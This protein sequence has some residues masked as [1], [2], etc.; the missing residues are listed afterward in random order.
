MVGEFLNPGK[1][2]PEASVLVVAHSKAKVV[3]SWL[4]ELG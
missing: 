4:Q 2:T 3:D 1:L